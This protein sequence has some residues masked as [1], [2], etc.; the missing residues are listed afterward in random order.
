MRPALR[1]A[2][3]AGG[4]RRAAARARRRLPAR[5]ARGGGSPCSAG[6]PPA[7]ARSRGSRTHRHG[8]YRVTRGDAGRV[9][10][11][12]RLGRR[13]GRARAVSARALLPAALLL[14]PP[15]RARRATRAHAQQQPLALTADTRDTGY[16]D[17]R[18]RSA[19]G[20]QVTISEGAEQL[21]AAHPDEAS[22]DLRR[23]ATVAL[24][25]ARADLHRHERRRP[26]R[27]RRR[28]HAVVRAPA[29]RSTRRAARAAAAAVRAAGSSTAGASAA[30]RRGCAWSR[31]AARPTAGA[32]ASARRRGEAA[33]FRALAPRRLADRG[34]HPLRAAPSAIVRARKPGGGLSLLA[35]GDSMIQIIDGFL[36][37][38]LA[39]ARRARAQRRPHQHRDLEAVAARLAGAGAAPGGA[40]APTS[41]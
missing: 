24:R 41:S 1:A 25:P 26:D 33:R 36:K 15:Q 20:V 32:S 9:P 4:R 35:T 37:A 28:A 39:P 21:A 8:R 10:G 6:P 22:T 14:D 30:S 29:R 31:R 11:Q 3:R 19:P 13:P 27:E 12:G 40:A 38:R 16:I 23:V 34:E 2:L 5:P 18:L 7:G 17:L